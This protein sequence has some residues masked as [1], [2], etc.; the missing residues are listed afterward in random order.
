MKCIDNPT[1]YGKVSLI[2]NRMKISIHINKRL[3]S[4]TYIKSECFKPNKKIKKVKPFRDDILGIN[5]CG[6]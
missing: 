1:I 3:E 6:L 5:R 4:P 2:N